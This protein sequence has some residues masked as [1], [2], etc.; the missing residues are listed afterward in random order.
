MSQKHTLPLLRNPRASMHAADNKAMYL[1]H[2]NLMNMVKGTL[3]EQE[4]NDVGGSMRKGEIEEANQMVEPHV[5]WLSCC[6]IDISLPT[7]C[8]PGPA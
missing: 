6:P 5:T 2:I 1:L 4:M 7:R 3:G 8:M